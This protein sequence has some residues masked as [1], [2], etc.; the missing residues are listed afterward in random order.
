MRIVACDAPEVALARRE[1]TA[2]V[3][4]LELADEMVLVR[5]SRTL[6]YR[7][8]VMKWQGRP[9]VLIATACAKTRFCPFKWHCWQTAS[10]SAGSSAA[11][12]TIVKSRPS[13]IFGCAACSSPGPWHR[14]QP[15]A[16]PAKK[17]GR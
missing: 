5:T 9:I 6:E 11:G 1:A 7:P 10:R 14:S 3:H 16:W 2:L 15:I 13:T 17:G 12:L 8:E 4:L